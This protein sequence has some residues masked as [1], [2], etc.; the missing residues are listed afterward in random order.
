MSDTPINHPTST[1]AADALRRHGEID[2]TVRTRS[3]W[4]RRYLLIYAAATVSLA[5][6]VGLAPSR[7]TV[8]VATVLWVVATGALSQWAK[9]QPVSPVGFARRHTAVIAVWALLWGAVVI[10]GTIWFHGNPAWWVPGA[11]LTAL[12]ALVAYRREATD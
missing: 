6:I 8:I 2:Q 4:F 5:L 12:P 1:Q 10:P 7:T 3:D 11:L 9:Q